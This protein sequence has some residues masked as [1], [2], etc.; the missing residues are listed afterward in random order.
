M[1]VAELHGLL[2]QNALPEQQLAPFQLAASRA[3]NLGNPGSKIGRLAW[4]VHSTRWKQGNEKSCRAGPA[5][6]NG[7]RWFHEN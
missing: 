2:H 1:K 6:N 4:P 7:E 3:A 5:R